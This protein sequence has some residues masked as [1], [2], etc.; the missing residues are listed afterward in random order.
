MQNSFKCIHEFDT[1]CKYFNYLAN[2]SFR[3]S[4]QSELA[5]SYINEQENET[6]QHKA[7]ELL[8]D[9]SVCMA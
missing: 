1:T 6:I 2:I 9:I 3:A 8:C 7:L 5:I 4:E